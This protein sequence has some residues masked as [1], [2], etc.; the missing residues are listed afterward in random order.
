MEI[1]Y[2]SKSKKFLKKLLK[3]DKKSVGMIIKTIEEY[4]FNPKGHFDIQ[5]LKGQLGDLKRIRVGNYRIIF[6]D[7]DNLLTILEIYHRQEAYS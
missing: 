6:D 1:I 3:G 2:S 4:A 5:Y 7:N